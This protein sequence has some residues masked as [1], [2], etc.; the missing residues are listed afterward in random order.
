MDP[1]GYPETLVATGPHTFHGI[2]DWLQYLFSVM[3]QV[4]AHLF[5]ISDASTGIFWT[6]SHKQWQVEGNIPAMTEKGADIV[7]AVMTMI[8]N[9]LI[10]V[11]QL[12]TLLPYDA[13]EI[14]IPT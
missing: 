13:V 6:E 5:Q 14:G 2:I 10:F 4:F 8:H 3:N 12:S 1:V 11:A 9:G 7:G